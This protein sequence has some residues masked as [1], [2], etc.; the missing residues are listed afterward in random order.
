MHICTGVECP[1]IEQYHITHIDLL[2]SRQFFFQDFFGLGINVNSFPMFSVGSSVS[3][4]EERSKEPG[5]IQTLRF[6]DLHQPPTV[7]LF[8]TPVPKCPENCLNNLGDMISSETQKGVHEA[9]ISD[10]KI[11]DV[12]KLL[13]SVDL[14]FLCVLSSDVAFLM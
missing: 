9:D 6:S 4:A 3:P 11:S 5:R 14:S 2:L 10:S 12:L 13:D 7:D 1:L 8:S